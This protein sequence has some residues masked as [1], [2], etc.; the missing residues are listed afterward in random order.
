MSKRVVCAV[1]DRAI[2]GFMMPFCAPTGAMA[3][4]SFADEVNK[5]DGPMYSHPDDYELYQLGFFDE[6]SGEFENKK[7]MLSIAKNVL[8]P[9]EV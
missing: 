5:P 7:Q 3:I 4:R 9:K 8:K 6:E 2:D 1:R